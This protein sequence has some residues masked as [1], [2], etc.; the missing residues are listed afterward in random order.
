MTRD[1]MQARPSWRGT[2]NPKFPLV[3]EVAG[4]WWVLRLNSFPDHSMWTLFVAG[5]VRGDLTT[6][7]ANW[8]KLD[9]RAAPPLEPGIVAAVLTPIENFVAYG[10]EVGQPCDDPFCCG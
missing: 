6:V 7:P 2:G 8:G 4:Q 1:V 9:I 5:A 10:S 3:A